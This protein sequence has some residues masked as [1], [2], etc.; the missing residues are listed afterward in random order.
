MKKEWDRIKSFT[1]RF[2]D[3]S[4]IAVANFSATAISGIFWFYMASL[5]GAEHYGQ[6][7]YIIAISGVTGTIAML[8]AGNTITVYAAKGEKILAQFSWLT[9][10]SSAIASTI[11]FVILFNIGAGLYVF[12][13]V[14]FTLVTADIL[15][16]K[17]YKEYSK[18]LI[19]Q[20]ILMIVLGT[21]MYFVWG[22]NGII[23]GIALSYFPYFK[24]LYEEIKNMRIDF[25]VLRSKRN[26]IINNYV[27]DLSRVFI[28]S[29]DK[30][31]I[32][33]LFGLTILGNYQLGVQF[34]SLLTLIPNI[35][36]QYILPHDASGTSH[37]RLKI[38]TI[39]VS[40]LLATIAVLIAPLVLPVLFPK[41]TKAIEV[42]Q[43]ISIAIIPNSVILMYVSK[44]LGELKIKILLCSSGLYLTV[45][46]IAVI[47]LG[48]M[49]GIK[50]V[51]IGYVFAA[52][53]EAAFLAIVSKW[54]K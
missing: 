46:I 16:R 48:Q 21:T 10:I 6:V 24:R 14:I 54:T 33:P 30:I 26:F 2:K 13:Y 32:A 19:T 23:L 44:F 5:I 3:L 8:G 25:S 18:Y 15:G 51:A 40:I 53:V 43:I 27:L 28:G 12:G 11:L 35:V 34:L 4:S 31:V 39:I 7:S 22:T 37:G 17:L 47:L 29:T 20:R 41:F 45:Q 52:S 50:G 42:V 38:A 9:I 1:R 36:Y 49:I